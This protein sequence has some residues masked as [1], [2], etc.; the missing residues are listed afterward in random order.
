M[1][2]QGR[3]GP[4]PGARSPRG[5]KRKSCALVRQKRCLIFSSGEWVLAG[6]GQGHPQWNSGIRCCSALTA[7]RILCSRPGSSRF[8]TTSSSETNPSGA[9]AARQSAW[10]F[11]RRKAQ[12]IEVHTRRRPEP[13]VRSA[14]RRPQC[15]F[16]R[17]RDGPCFAGTVFSRN[18]RRRRH[19]LKAA[20]R[21]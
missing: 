18:G 14:A 16:V 10:R 6:K 11:W 7:A 1:L 2:S 12:G 3:G 13:C 9:R 4:N 5:M 8:S 15:R 20:S 21:E 17:R 19:D